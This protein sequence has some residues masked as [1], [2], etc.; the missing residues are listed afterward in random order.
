VYA[1][2]VLVTELNEVVE[3]CGAAVDPVPNVMYVGELGVRAAGEA[4]SLVAA[5]DLQTLGIAGV[6]PCPAQV[7]A[8]A[9]RPIG[10]NEHFGVTGPPAG[11]LPGNRAQDVEFLTLVRR[12]GAVM[13]GDAGHERHCAP[14]D[15]GVTCPSL[16]WAGAMQTLNG[17]GAARDATQTTYR[18]EPRQR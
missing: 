12:N 16:R 2:V 14:R 15:G 4:T 3:I 9:V 11:D 13:L 1:A 5:P 7:E 18:P 10:R 8:S 17:R 6:S